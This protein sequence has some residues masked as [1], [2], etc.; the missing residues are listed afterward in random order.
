MREQSNTSDLC[1]LVRQGT[2]CKTSRWS[3]CSPLAPGGGSQSGG[4]GHPPPGW[5]HIP[6]FQI[7]SVGSVRSGRV[8]SVARLGPVSRVGP[9]GRACPG[10]PVGG[11]GKGS[12]GLIE[13]CVSARRV[14]Q[15]HTEDA[16][17]VRLLREPARLLLGRALAAG[18]IRLPPLPA[19]SLPVVGLP[20]VGLPGVAPAVALP[21]VGLP[22]V[23][24]PAAG[25]PGVALPGVGGAAR[26][27]GVGRVP[28]VP[29]GPLLAGPLAVVPRGAL[30][31]VRLQVG[32]VGPVSRA[33][34]SGRSGQSVGSVRSVGAAQSGGP[35]SRV[36]R[37]G[38]VRRVGP[39]KPR[40]LRRLASAPRPA[41][42]AG[43]CPPGGRTLAACCG[44]ARRSRRPEPRR[45][46]SPERLPAPAR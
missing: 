19:V 42:C 33:G 45:G 3:T 4:W 17:G 26:R 40:S 6:H 8:R 10:G 1:G 38:S 44:R 16:E 13:D 30:A 12:C 7:Q 5:G 14:A 39:V 21:V 18:D 27:G 9:V 37:A 15:S 46:S 35:V 34:R 29:L 23:A 11:W 20:V 43:G 25:L 22:G 28:L 24:L 31:E 32:C 36:G 41:G 2:Y